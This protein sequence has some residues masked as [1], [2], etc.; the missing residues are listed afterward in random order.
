MLGKNVYLQYI[1]PLLLPILEILL[2]LGKI[3][4]GESTPHRVSKPEKRTTS[5]V[6]EKVAGRRNAYPSRGQPCNAP[7][8]PLRGFHTFPHI[9]ETHPPTF[10]PK[11]SQAII[12]LAPQPLSLRRSTAGAGCTR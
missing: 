2:P 8:I 7:F 12:L 9:V 3:G 10:G 11:P 6:N 1:K 4:I 5:I